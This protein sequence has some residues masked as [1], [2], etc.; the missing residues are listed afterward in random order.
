MSERK[1][2]R[3]AEK[4]FPKLSGVA[5]LLSYEIDPSLSKRYD[6]R[7]VHRT[8]EKVFGYGNERYWLYI[9]NGD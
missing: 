7:L 5:I 8:E 9:A 4:V 2:L 3:R 6:L 1:V